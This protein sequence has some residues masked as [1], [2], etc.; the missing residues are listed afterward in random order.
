M[1]GW[2]IL[3]QKNILPALCRRMQYDCTS[4]LE[5]R[6]F[7]NFTEIEA[8]LMLLQ[9]RIPKTVCQSKS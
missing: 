2:K 6:G 1:N 8:V 3:I 5:A 4:I 7:R 9:K